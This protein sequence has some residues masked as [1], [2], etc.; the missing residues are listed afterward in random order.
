MAS[1]WPVKDDSTAVLMVSFFRSMIKQGKPPAEALRAT[2]IEML[3]S[4]R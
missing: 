4:D 2:Q 1:L 3:K